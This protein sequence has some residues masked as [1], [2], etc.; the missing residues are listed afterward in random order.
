MQSLPLSIVIPGFN[1]Q[2][3]IEP[4]PAARENI[5]SAL[6]DPEATA[7]FYF[8]TEPVLS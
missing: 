6:A 4:A 2:G 7:D 3:T 8:L 1:E 5:G